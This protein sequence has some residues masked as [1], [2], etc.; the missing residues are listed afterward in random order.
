MI[1]TD[2]VSV[3][4]HLK[5]QFD[6]LLVTACASTK[7]IDVSN[8]RVRIN[9]FFSSEVPGNFVTEGNW[10]CNLDK[11]E[12]PESILLHLI[13]A[14]LIGYLN[15]K[16]IEVFVIA[17]GNDSGLKSFFET[18]EKEY[19]K[20]FQCDFSSLIK[21]FCDPK[22]NPA[23]PS[24]T[25]PDFKLRIGTKWE[26][27]RPLSFIKAFE[28]RFSWAQHLLIL[29]II[30]NCIII[31]YAVLPFFVSA[32]VEDLSDP[33]VI[34]EL[35]QQDIN[36]ELSPLLQV[37]AYLSWEENIKVC[38]Y[39]DNVIIIAASSDHLYF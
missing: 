34:A 2:A 8:V 26:D 37:M 10:L 22:L 13:R 14:K 16:L 32:A 17:S 7:N 20:L 25:L 39:N 29:E 36:V 30:P 3:A 28:M 9:S 23:L 38:E 15:Y 1:G 12:T 33:E 35:E 5:Q 4:K 21:V 31:K 19:S 18:Y 27:S 11:C 24:F 6:E